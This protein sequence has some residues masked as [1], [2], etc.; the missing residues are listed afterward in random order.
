L[1]SLERKNKT[2]IALGTYNGARFLPEQ[3]ESFLSQTRHPDEIIVCDDCSQDETVAIIEKFT[4]SAPFEVKLYINSQNLGSTKNFEKAVG[5]CSGNIVF[6]SDQDDVW[7][8]RKIE[9][10]TAEFEKNPALGLV[11]TDAE[12]VDEN[13]APLGRKLC[14]LTFKEQF[15]HIDTSEKMLELLMPRNYITGATMAFRNNLKD[16]FLPIPTDI[17]EMIHDAWISLIIVLKS[18]F[19]F[20]DE[21]LIKYRQ[22]AGQQLGVNV[23]KKDSESKIEQMRRAVRVIKTE[24]ERIAKIRQYFQKSPLLVPE[25]TKIDKVICLYLAEIAEK[26]THYQV[27]TN[28]P[29][30]KLKRIAVV[31]K[32]WQ[33]GRYGKFSKGTLSAIKDFLAKY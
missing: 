29:L 16:W 6:L 25:L 31:K 26:L 17:P 11:F 8:S 15:R 3:L 24:Q 27:R 4:A 23:E 1:E 9:K 5:L 28:L 13:L 22:H 30:P 14:D 20:F 33:S 10:I 7:D 19:K 32:E 21:P 2:S 18:D 12:L